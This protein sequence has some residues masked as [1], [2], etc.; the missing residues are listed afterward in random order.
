MKSAGFVILAD[1]LVL[2]GLLSPWR[3]QIV[4][5]LGGIYFMLVAIWLRMKDSGHDQS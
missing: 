2:A 5:L 1:L 4:A 3:W